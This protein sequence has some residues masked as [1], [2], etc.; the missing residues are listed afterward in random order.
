[1]FS[2]TAPQKRQNSVNSTNP[3]TAAR[4]LTPKR[5]DQTE[6]VLSFAETRSNRDCEGPSSSRGD[7]FNSLSTEQRHESQANLVWRAFTL[8]LSRVRA[9]LENVSCHEA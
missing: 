1:M 4:V 3:S 6:L 7:V 5:D 8:R 9:R 2:S